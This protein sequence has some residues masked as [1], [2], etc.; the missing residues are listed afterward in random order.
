MLVETTLKRIKFTKAG[1]ISLKKTIPHISDQK[2]AIFASIVKDLAN[3]THS[4][5]HYCASMYRAG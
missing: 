2:P 4:I 1:K 5:K 3:K